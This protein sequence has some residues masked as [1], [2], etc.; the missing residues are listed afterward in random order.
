MNSH[1]SPYQHHHGYTDVTVALW[2]W[3]GNRNGT[4]KPPSRTHLDHQLEPS[5]GASRPCAWASPAWRIRERVLSEENGEGEMVENM[6]RHLMH[7][8]GANS[9]QGGR[10]F[11]GGFDL[12][13]ILQWRAI[14]L[15]TS[16]ASWHTAYIQVRASRMGR[17]IVDDK[18]WIKKELGN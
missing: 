14:I 5:R 7:G 15:I 11:G 8:K 2:M 6:V 4:N 12:A 1:E 9:K 17:G 10:G 13:W 18:I 16:K 3:W